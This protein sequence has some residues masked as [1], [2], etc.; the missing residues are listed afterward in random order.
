MRLML[1]KKFWNIV[2]IDELKF[3][4]FG[5]RLYGFGVD[6]DLILKWNITDDDLK[7]FQKIA[8]LETDTK[9]DFVVD[10]ERNKD[11]VKFV[12]ERS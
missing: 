5:S 12:E 7:Q 2:M 11:F 10:N 9:K 4:F 1:W 6:I 8:F 3:I